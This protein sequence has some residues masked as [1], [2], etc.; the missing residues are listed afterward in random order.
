MNQR[1]SYVK[2]P[3]KPDR[4]SAPAHSRAQQH[5]SSED[6]EVIDEA[7]VGKTKASHRAASLK[8]EHHRRTRRPTQPKIPHNNLSN[9]A[10]ASR[11]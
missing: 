2:Q 10:R 5:Q 1:R 6:R 8:S 7:P 4:K 11:N 3:E 9:D